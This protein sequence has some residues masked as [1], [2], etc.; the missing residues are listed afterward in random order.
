[1]AEER[2]KAAMGGSEKKS[3]KK[4]KKSKAPK[5]KIKHMNIRPLTS[6]GF[7]AEH[8]HQANANGE[9]PPM[10]EHSLPDVASLQDHVG[11][12]F[13]PQE[14]EPQPPAGGGAPQQMMPGA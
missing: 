11:E 12:H 6:G 4:S 1:M 3:K 13:G 8:N 14:E 2:A 5:H 10:E 7:L 9:V